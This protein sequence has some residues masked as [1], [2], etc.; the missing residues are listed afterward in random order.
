[1]KITLN[2]YR[3]KLIYVTDELS[4]TKIFVIKDHVKNLNCHLD[5]CLNNLKDKKFTNL[6]PHSY[7]PDNTSKSVVTSPTFSLLLAKGIY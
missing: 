3:K 2:D 7:K 5:T 4:V 6:Q 1:M